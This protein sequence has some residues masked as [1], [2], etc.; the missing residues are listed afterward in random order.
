MWIFLHAYRDE[1]FR[2][3]R[4][5]PVAVY[6]A[7]LT[8]AC[9]LVEWVRLCWRRE[10]LGSVGAS[11]LRLLEASL[12]PS[13]MR[14]VHGTAWYL[15]GVCVSLAA[16][17]AD[18]AVLSICCLAWCDPAASFV[19]K[20]LGEHPRFGGR[21]GS[22]KSFAGTAA[23]ALT[24]AATTA[25]LFS[26]VFIGPTTAVN[27]FRT[28][29]PPP[30]RASSMF[31]SLLS[32]LAV[33]SVDSAAEVEGP[34]AW[35]LAALALIGGATAAATELLGSSHAEAD[36]RAAAAAAARKGGKGKHKGRTKANAG[37][38]LEM[39][40]RSWADVAND[41]LMIPVVT[42]AVMYVARG[43]ILG[44]ID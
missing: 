28:A 41:N 35:R 26:A 32:R 31:K 27:P 13:E 42:G 5:H 37:D 17:P 15:L 40:R 2:T 34:E 24:G 21:F 11:G 16:Y 9:W 43:F 44:W 14:R 10:T 7:P 23:C 19:G 22:G 8:A 25:A 12:R 33:D 4:A 39:G 30:P 6:L 18:V 36:A 20:A 1:A 38:L 3:W 29:P